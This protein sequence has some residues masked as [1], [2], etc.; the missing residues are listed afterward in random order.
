M[1]DTQ[2]PVGLAWLS[3]WQLRKYWVAKIIPIEGEVLL[4]FLITDIFKPQICI[5]SL[6]FGVLETYD[7]DDDVAE[8][9]RKKSGLDV[10]EQRSWYKQ[11]LLNFFDE[12]KE[13]TLEGYLLES[14]Y[15]LTK[16]KSVDFTINMYRNAIKLLPTT[17]VYSDCIS[18]EIDYLFEHPEQRNEE[19]FRRIRDLFENVKKEEVI[20]P[21]AWEFCVMVNYCLTG[22]LGEDTSRCLYLNDVEKD[23]YKKV[24][25]GK[26]YEVLFDAQEV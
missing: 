5:Q 21:E 1:K 3:R 8:M 12:P 18:N 25:K 9:L 6:I 2:L 10:R 13:R 16:R 19:N 11:M 23:S 4:P 17:K 24:I 14:L 26:D 22:L 15:L 7:L 20:I